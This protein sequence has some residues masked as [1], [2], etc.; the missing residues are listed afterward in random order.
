MN[1]LMIRDAG[2]WYAM[3]VGGDGHREIRIYS[4]TTP[5][6]KLVVAYV[7]EME[8]ARRNG[9]LK[10]G[11]VWHTSPSRAAKAADRVFRAALE[12]AS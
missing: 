11:Y 1:A 12:R 4:A 9:A 10:P 2:I 8:D 5:D 7:R 6:E 3:E